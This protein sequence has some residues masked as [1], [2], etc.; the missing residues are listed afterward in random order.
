MP[1]PLIRSTRPG[2]Q[3]LGQPCPET[4]D[5]RLAERRKDPLHQIVEQAIVVLR[6]SREDAV[7]QARRIRPRHHGDGRE[8]VAG[9][10]EDVPDRAVAVVD[11]IEYRLGEI[12]E[13]PHQVQCQVR[14]GLGNP[15]DDHRPL[16]IE[17]LQEFP[18][19]L[20]VDEG[21]GGPQGGE[22][23]ADFGG[24]SVAT[25][26]LRG[27]L[28]AQTPLDFGVS[29]REVDEDGGEA[30]RAQR[31]QIVQVEGLLRR[32]AV[33]SPDAFEPAAGD[34]GVMDGVL[35]I[36]MAEVVLDQPQ[37]V[38]SVGQGEPARVTEHMGV[39]PGPPG[40]D[41]RGGD[42]VVHRLPCQ[43]L[44]ALRQEQ[45]GQCVLAGGQIAPDMTQL[46]M[47]IN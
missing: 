13:P 3:R 19:L 22:A 43:R 5:A 6:E 23:L 32:H 37:I 21:P 29:G 44:A 1:V 46:V 31:R 9:R 38:S 10:V 4:G 34:P 39:D 7:R 45:P 41:G 25:A 14:S 15:V 42:Q 12:H 27:Q 47:A 20:P 18:A 40:S 30:F 16:L 33:M 28:Q 36:A 2:G 8:I 17:I 35:G 24:E 11:A 26:G